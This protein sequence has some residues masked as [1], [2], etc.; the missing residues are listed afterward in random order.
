MVFWPD[1]AGFILHSYV[2]NGLHGKGHIIA[3]NSFGKL[4]KQVLAY[5]EVED[6]RGMKSEQ[7]EGKFSIFSLLVDD[8]KMSFNESVL[9]GFRSQGKMEKIQLN[10]CPLVGRENSFSVDKGL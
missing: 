9:L 7:K 2:L 5:G 4:Y 8:D 10:S 6:E 1:S 3:P